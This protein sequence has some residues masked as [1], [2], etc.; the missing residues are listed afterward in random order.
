MLDNAFGEEIFPKDQSK[1]LLVRL[2]VI[3]SCLIASYLREETNTHL[4]TTTFRV[5]VEGN[6]VSLQPPFVSVPSATPHKT[7]SLDPSPASLVFIR[8]TSAPQF[9]SWSEGPKTEHNI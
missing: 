2:Q 9:F 6:K 3:S 8:C 1:S 4:A 7:F 5:V